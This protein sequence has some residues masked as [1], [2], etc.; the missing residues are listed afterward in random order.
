MNYSRL[1]NYRMAAY[2]ALAVG[3]INLRYQTGA[4]ENL[5]KSLA[6][7]IPGILL[8]AI[9]FIEAGKK[10]LATKAAAQAVTAIWVL[11]LLYSFIV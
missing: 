8:L 7:I 5:L 2:G 1:N 11:L 10:W 3:L 4:D 6:L 9:S